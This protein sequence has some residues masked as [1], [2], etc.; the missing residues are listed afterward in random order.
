MINCTRRNFI[1][2]TSLGL[3][4]AGAMNWNGAAEAGSIHD[5]TARQSPDW[6]AKGIVYQISLRGFTE[7]G[8][9]KAAEEKLESIAK[10]GVTAVYLCPVFVSDD[11]MNKDFW[12]SRQKAS[13]MENP[14]NPYRMKDY[15]N[16]DPE[17]GTNQDLKDFINAAHALGLRVMLDMVFFHCGPK[18]VFIE[19]HPDFVQRN[20]N[21]AVK[22]GRWH[23]PMLNY[24][25][26]ELRE[27][28]I[29]NME[30]WVRDYKADGFRMDVGNLVPLDFWAEARKRCEKINPEVGFINEGTNPQSLVE[31]FDVNYS[32]SFIG[33]LNDAFCGRKPASAY[34]SRCLSIA[35][36]NVQNARFL[37]YID[38][39][40][41]ASDKRLNRPEQQYT[42]D[43]VNAVLTLL[44]TQDGV[45]MLYGGQEVAD[46]SPQCLFGNTAQ[47]KKVNLDNPAVCVDWSLA[48]TPQ[49]LARTALIQRLAALRRSNDVF[50]AGKIVWLENDKM[51]SVLAFRRELGDKNALVVVNA[52]K[53]PV[54][55]W[56]NSKVSPKFAPIQNGTFTDLNYELPPYGYVV[57]TDSEE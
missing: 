49:G 16:V 29:Q 24:K 7:Q 15:Y 3:I 43:G 35:S 9:L 50:T 4:A 45:P 40:D 41:I 20:E 54:K 46:V 31:A 52:T 5:K 39:H 47:A 10:L 51:D 8:T 19:S 21:G 12:S 28:L 17:Y 26:P 36:Q 14:C 30:Q 48:Q 22:N 38:N 2:T 1:K 44:F 53:N 23:F 13:G 33:T 25:S 42:F 27:Y 18:A 34:R 6:L 56:V 37:R 55:V 57:R 32:F 11:D